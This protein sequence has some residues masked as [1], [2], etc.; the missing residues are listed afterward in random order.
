MTTYRNIYV[1]IK[2][3]VCNKWGSRLGESII[4]GKLRHNKIGNWIYWTPE[5]WGVL[6]QRKCIFHVL[7]W[8]APGGAQGL[9]LPETWNVQK[10]SVFAQSKFQ[11]VSGPWAHPAPPTYHMK[12]AF[13]LQEYP[14]LSGV[15]YIQFPILLWLSFPKMMLSPR[16]EPHLS[17]KV[18][19]IRT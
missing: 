11:A 6:L 15:Q 19:L 4:F 1:F 2:W 9:K 13:S 8:G 16:R 3:T 12:Y 17:Q 7:C 14:Q 18:N 5:S 10:H